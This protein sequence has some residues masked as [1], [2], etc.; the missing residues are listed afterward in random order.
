MQRR[1]RL[2]AASEVAERLGEGL[3]DVGETAERLRQK[4]STIRHKILT[5]Q[6][7]FVKIGRSVRIPIAE[8]ERLLRDGWRAPITWSGPSEP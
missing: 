8:V 2:L 4:K 6:I 7:G 1:D 5:R 3:L